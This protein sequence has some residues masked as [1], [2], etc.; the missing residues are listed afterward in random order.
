VNGGI[1]VK[2]G[3][4]TFHWA[5]NY[6]AVLQAYALQQTLIPMG[7]EATVLDYRPPRLVS[8]IGPLGLRS[9]RF[10]HAWA[11]RRRFDHFRR[12][13]LRLTK[14]VSTT[15]ALRE[16][17]R[18]Y[19]VVIVGSDQVWNLNIIRGDLNYFLAFAN[20]VRKVS[21]AADFG[22]P[23]EIAPYRTDLARLLARFDRI[24]VRTG[25]SRE[26]VAALSP[27]DA[28]IV[29]DPTLLHDFSA[30]AA[31]VRIAQPYILVY[32]LW[33][34]TD[35]DV[36]AALVRK[37]ASAS[38]LPVYSVS[39]A[40]DFPV[41][42]CHLR[43]LGP[44]EW[45]SSFQNAAFVCT[46]SYHGFLFAVKNRKPFL[47]VC[48]NQRASRIVEVA[49]RYGL[50]DSVV[51]SVAA[52]E[53]YRIGAPAA[54]PDRVH[55]LLHADIEASRAFLREAVCAPHAGSSTQL[56]QPGAKA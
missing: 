50:L 7:V 46:D 24:S 2:A 49:R 14:R 1:V 13:H 31:P 43:R 23:Q 35:S 56:P 55:H 3:I 8:R 15:E 42:D 29:L 40:R 18:G 52:A 54:D 28:A 21:Y 47:A 38:G 5:Y 26:M 25:L 17:T 44:A 11:L 30:V 36:L 22:Q 39:S 33:R 12:R 32:S 27:H 6:G 45:L 41:A 51:T 9:G 19:D 37:V 10:V 34:G 48:L 53:S 20:G 4:L 16:A